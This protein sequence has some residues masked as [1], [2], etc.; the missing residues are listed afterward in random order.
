MR[1]VSVHS[2]SRKPCMVMTYNI[3]TRETVGRIGRSYMEAHRDRLV[4]VFSVVR[5]V[6]G[7]PSEVVPK[8][9][10]SIFQCIIVPLRVYSG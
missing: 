9:A 10:C 5:W 1:T 4:Y 7:H 2:V 8:P 6:G 3:T